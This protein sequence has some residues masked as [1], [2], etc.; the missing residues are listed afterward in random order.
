MRNLSFEEKNEMI[1][2]NHKQTNKQTNKQHKQTNK[3]TKQTNKQ[4]NKQ[5]KQTNNTNKQT[6]KQTTQNKTK[7]TNNTNKMPSSSSFLI[8][9]LFITL[10]FSLTHSQSTAA[11]AT[12]TT[13]TTTATTTTITPSLF[14]SLPIILTQNHSSITLSW[15]LRSFALYLSSSTTASPAPFLRYACIAT[16]STTST[17]STLSSDNT[18]HILSGNDVMII[19]ETGFASSLIAQQYGVASVATNTITLPIEENALSEA[20]TFPIL[21]MLLAY[22]M[23]NITCAVSLSNNNS[24]ALHA[25]DVASIPPSPASSSTPTDTFYRIQGRTQGD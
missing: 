8:L 10:S 12:A 7:Q 11:T 17:T 20:L 25:F 6:N 22:T 4:T 15:D 24:V 14:A 5:T 13:T 1:N 21:P 16:T 3:Q 23:Y 2:V 18:R 9:L 19:G